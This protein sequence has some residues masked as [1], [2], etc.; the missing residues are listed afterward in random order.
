MSVIYLDKINLS[1]QKEHILK[2][3]SFQLDKGE[4][5]ALLGPNGVG[6][7]TLIDVI[8]KAI[9]PDS[10]EAKVFETDYMKVKGKVGVLF[11]SPP[12]F[13]LLKVKEI[14]NYF[15][16]IYGV[17]Y[18][19]NLVKRLGIDTFES[20]LFGVLSKGQKKKT[21]IVL[22]TMHQPELLILDEPTSELDPF[23]RAEAWKIFKDHQ[24]SILFT[25]HIWSEAKQYADKIA[26]IYDGR[27]VGVDTPQNFTTKKYINAER[28]LV[29]PKKKKLAAEVE[30]YL[31]YELDENYH[32]FPENIQDFFD[33]LSIPISNYSILDIELEDIYHFLTNSTKTK[34]NE[35]IE[36]IG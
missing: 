35:S 17:S 8:T 4:I 32:L 21:G 30:N 22:T 26:F 1:Y 23:M 27:I 12:L 18:P 34:Q 2:N 14:I 11:D 16:T 7:S 9:K 31:H 6:K 33:N 29:L 15:C 25:T 28:K 13:P 3:V 10:G 19:E 36:Y 24:R 5:V 20:K